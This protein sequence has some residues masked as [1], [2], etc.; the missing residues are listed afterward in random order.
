MLSCLTPDQVILQRV[1]C[2]DGHEASTIMEEQQL[3]QQGTHTEST[4]TIFDNHCHDHRPM[5]SNNT[6][7][8][9]WNK[10][11]CSA[12]CYLQVPSTALR[13]PTKSPMLPTHL[14]TGNVWYRR[15]TFAGDD[16][17]NSSHCGKAKGRT[18]DENSESLKSPEKCWPEMI[19]SNHRP[20][21]LSDSVV[22]SLL[23][24][25]YGWW[26]HP[27]VFHRLQSAS[28]WLCDFM[29]LSDPYTFSIRSFA[30]EPFPLSLSPALW[31]ICPTMCS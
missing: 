12:P 7:T 13:L 24:A 4:L 2:D 25:N 18:I 29:I 21:T 31:V 16:V 9:F 22:S 20:I 3:N 15:G 6:Q 28:L 1:E 17:R 5:I 23:R 11:T 10:V 8:L 30:L 26:T 19:K 14:A 27:L